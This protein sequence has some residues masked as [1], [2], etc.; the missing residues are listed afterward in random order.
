MKIDPKKIA[1]LEMAAY[2]REDA[3]EG[4]S[5]WPSLAL[6]SQLSES[7]GY[8]L[9]GRV[10]A[11]RDFQ[12]RTI[13][14]IRRGLSRV[15]GRQVALAE[16]VRNADLPAPRG[17]TEPVRVSVNGKEKANTQRGGAGRR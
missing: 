7:Y 12:N 13:E 10:R 11:R 2:Q 9:A 16:F 3:P 17:G 6:A 14:K 4:F 5:F 1:Q 15:L 8:Q